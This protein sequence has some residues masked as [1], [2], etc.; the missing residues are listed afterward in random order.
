MKFESFNS[1][2]FQYTPLA[3]PAAAAAGVN[4]IEKNF[5]SRERDKSL[6]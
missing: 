2:H 6:Q 4:N 3:P 5:I 1:S